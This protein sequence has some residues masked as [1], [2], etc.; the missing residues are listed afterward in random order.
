MFEL[1]LR[2][3]LPLTLS[4][5][6]S[7]KLS[8]DDDD[9]VDEEDTE[10]ELQNDDDAEGADAADSAGGAVAAGATE[11][12]EELFFSLENKEPNIDLLFSGTG[13]LA[14]PVF[15]LSTPFRFSFPDDIIGVV[16][17]SDLDKGVR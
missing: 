11:G 8:L 16:K 15:P 3:P 4:A 12:D 10:E 5:R 14:F 6:I 7:K 2:R 1:D 13:T 9:E 17:K